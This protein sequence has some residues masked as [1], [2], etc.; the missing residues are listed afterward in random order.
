MFVCFV[1]VAFFNIT[2]YM[3]LSYMPSYL[4]EI[5]GLSSTVGTLLIT[6]LMIINGATYF[7]VWKAQ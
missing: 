7:N 3:L 1:A 4:D 6:I 5:I 2:S